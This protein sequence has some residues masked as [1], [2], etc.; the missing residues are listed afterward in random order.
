MKPLLFLFVG[1]L[2]LVSAQ[3]QD[4]Y[5]VTSLVRDLCG[6]PLAVKTL[7]VGTVTTLS[8]EES[9]ATRLY[10]ELITAGLVPCTTLTMVDRSK[11]NES[12]REVALSQTGETSDQVELQEG[13]LLNAQAILSV[14]LA[15]LEA[16][17]ELSCKMVDVQTSK[18][19]F[20][21]IYR[22][23]QEAPA[24]LEKGTE[25]Q[26]APTKASAGQSSVQVEVINVSADQ[27]KTSIAFKYA[28]HPATGAVDF[29]VRLYNLQRRDPGYYAKVSET[30]RGIAFVTRDEQ[31]YSVFAVC[32]GPTSQWL[33]K[34]HPRVFAVCEKKAAETEQNRPGKARFVRQYVRSHQAFVAREPI[35]VDFV[36][37]RND[38]MAERIKSQLPNKPAREEE[39]VNVRVKARL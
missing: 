25:S 13:K 23:F 37:Q 31:S 33:R 3:S 22:D 28:V 30:Q 14:S 35:L 18:I 29:N 7:Y 19:V 36:A 21:K 15:Q 32:H 34:N 1:C 20:A 39:G 8:G 38:V 26:P 4:D 12:M 17:S 10:A 27:R 16:G 9:D 24:P 11:L 2:G 6:A 5:F